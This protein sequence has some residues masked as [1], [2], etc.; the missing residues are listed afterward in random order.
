M[1]YPQSL[2]NRTKYIFWRALTPLYPYVRDIF[3]ELGVIPHSGR[4]PFLLGSI[5]EN[6]SLEGFIRE[7]VKK[8]YGNHFIAWR[9][10]DELVG[11]R[12]TDGFKH[13]YHLR[14]FA[15]GAVHGHYEY[16][17]EAYPLFHLG[18]IGFEKRND[19]FLRQLGPLIIPAT[20]KEVAVSTDL[21]YS[22]RRFPNI[23]EKI[24]RMKWL[25]ASRAWR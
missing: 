13:Q 14:V 20:A 10:S 24:L 22:Y 11:L 7:L 9:D 23:I 15:D 21:Y 2:L 19:V 1:V 18:E 17:P 6:I 3:T 8:G 12:I 16:T 25:W 5:A 4:Q